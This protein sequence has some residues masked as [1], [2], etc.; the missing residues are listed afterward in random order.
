MEN[1]E[2]KSIINHK[3][4]LRVMFLREENGQA[5]GC[6]IIELVKHSDASNDLATVY[7]AVSVLNP[8]DRFDRALSRQLTIGRLVE[9]PYAIL[10]VSNEVKIHDITRLVMEDIKTNTKLPTRA[11]KAARIWLRATPKRQQE[12]IKLDPIDPNRT[13]RV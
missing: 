4:S 13:Y 7:Y 9:T 1:N 8:Q 2:K 10:N 12:V 3:K 6:V 11:R 5:C